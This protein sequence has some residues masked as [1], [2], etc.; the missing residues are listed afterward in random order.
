MNLYPEIKE[1]LKR[2]ENQFGEDLRT[3]GDFYSL[4][5]TIYQNLK[6]SISLS[7]LKRLW[8]YVSYT[9]RPRL[10]TLN[11]LSRYVGYRDFCAFCEALQKEDITQSEFL[12]SPH[13]EVAELALGTKLEVAW[14]PNRYLLLIYLGDTRFQVVEARNS[15]I[16]PGD[17]FCATQFIKGLPLFLTDFRREGEKGKMFLAGKE[18]GLTLLNTLKIE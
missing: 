13:I 12:S 17:E 15:K 1:L 3:P 18:G 16:L 8:G 11:I 9:S 5:R 4:T 6:V 2:V 7:T 14:E 10:T